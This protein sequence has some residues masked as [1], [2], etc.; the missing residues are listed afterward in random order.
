MSQASLD[1]SNLLFRLK[2][3]G[4]KPSKL[5]GQHFL[6]DRNILRKIADCVRSEEVS[7]ILEVGPGPGG[8]T[9]ELL[10]RGFK[11]FAIEKDR[12]FVEFLEDS[13]KKIYGEMITLVSAD[14]LTYDV[15]SLNPKPDVLVSNLPYNIAATLIVKYLSDFGFIKR[16]VVTVQKEVALRMAAKPNRKDYG[17]LSVKVQTLADVKLLFKIKPGAFYPPP[18]VDSQVVLIE[19]NPK[20][21][22]AEIKDFFSFVDSCFSHRRKTLVNNLLEAKIFKSRQDAASFVK[23]CS[24]DERLR[25]ESLSPDMFKYCY[26]KLREFKN[27]KKNTEKGKNS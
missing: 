1:P 26:E 6:F 7:C 23:S 5:L 20:L 12:R 11:V 4:I 10:S 16:Y 8:L 19:R 25:P 3:Y 24:I 9:S 22:E 15:G 2:E 18:K 13:L 21:S 27:V 17:A 14:A